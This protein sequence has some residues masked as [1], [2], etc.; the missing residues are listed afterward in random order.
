MKDSKRNN[1][2][3]EQMKCVVC[4][5]IYYAKRNTSKYCSDLCKQ[6]CHELRTQNRNGYFDDV[7]LGTKLEHGTIPSQQMPESLLVL[8]G[9]KEELLIKLTSFLSSDQIKNEEPFIDNIQPIVETK[10]WFESSTQIFS[11]THLLE[12]MQIN[13]TTYKLYADKWRSD[14]E[15]PFPI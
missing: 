9:N 2:K 11:K 1:V 8:T 14:D 5:N 10:D 4:G 12:V 13:Q 3:K 15:K 7:N 6:Q